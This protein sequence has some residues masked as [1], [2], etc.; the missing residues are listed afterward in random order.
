MIV[1]CGKCQ[2][3]YNLPDAKI[4]EAGAKVKC[5]KCGNVFLAQ[6]PRPESLKDDLP[7]SLS[8]SLDDELAGLGGSPSGSRPAPS[9]KSDDDSLD[10]LF[11]DSPATSPAPGPSRPSAD[12]MDFGGEDQPSSRQEDDNFQAQG[13]PTEGFNLEQPKPEK[14]K[15]ELSRKNLVILLAAGL[16]LLGGGGAGYFFL[17]KPQ[18]P[19]T[20]TKD[21]M[22]NATAQPAPT[23]T[24][25]AAPPQ[26][27]AQTQA[28]RTK[29]ISLKNVRQYYVTNEKVGQI[30]VVDGKAGND[31]TTPKEMIRVE[32]SIYDAQGNVLVA[33]KQICGNTLSHFQLQVQTLDEIEK[34]LNAEVGILTNNTFIKPGMDVPFMLIFANPPESLKEFGITVI[35]AEDP[36]P[37]PSDKK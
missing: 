11:S 8:S 36:A 15:F 9:Q 3:K 18:A 32:A 34:G 25:L 28:E 12:D 1:Q 13:V 29:S 26:P 17:S 2:T 19:S 16:L 37:E 6:K 23:P 30:F 4:P 31:F 35:G 7:D 27:P 22:A 24:A 20:S 21:A 33:K 5:S 14:K 10:D